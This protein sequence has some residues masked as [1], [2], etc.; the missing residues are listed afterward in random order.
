MT[1]TPEFGVWVDLKKRC[2]DQNF[3]HYHD[4]GGRG[5]KVCNRWLNSF[6]N[7]YKDMGPRPSDK[8]QIE[9]I[10]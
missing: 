4:Y 3:H 7:F 9:R 10:I 2:C 1:N 8:Y 6:E 5:I